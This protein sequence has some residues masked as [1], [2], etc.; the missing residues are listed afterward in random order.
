KKSFQGSSGLRIN[1]SSSRTPSFMVQCPGSQ[2][3]GLKMP[4][5][6][7]TFAAAS[8]SAEGTK[9]GN[10]ESSNGS[11]NVT[12]AP[13]RNVRREMCFFVMNIFT[14]EASDSSETACSGRFQAPLQKTGNRFWPLRGQ[15]SEPPAYR[16]T[17]LHDPE[18]T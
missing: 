7:G 14:P 2:P 1:G 12:P 15:S 3:C 10:I 8:A 4:T 9:A 11:A 6:R 5:N 17:L 16:R 13:R 18:H